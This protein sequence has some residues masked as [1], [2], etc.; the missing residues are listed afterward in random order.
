[1]HLFQLYCSK[2]PTK[3]N[4]KQTNAKMITSALP[5]SNKPDKF[6][7]GTHLP[8]LAINDAFVLQDNN[9]PS[10]LPPSELYTA[11]TMVRQKTVDGA[12][13]IVPGLRLI[14]D[15]ILLWSNLTSILLL[16]I[17]CLLQVMVKY[18]V[19]LKIKKR[20]IFSDRF[21]YVGRDLLQV[22]NTTSQSKYESV[23]QWKTP[24]KGDDL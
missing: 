1:M 17:E 4:S 12:H 8:H 2:E 5:K 19:S 7:K 14:I 11:S 15:D 22:G 18:H 10:T 21:K 16:L 6:R 13:I 3:V 9:T 23:H 24:H 20:H